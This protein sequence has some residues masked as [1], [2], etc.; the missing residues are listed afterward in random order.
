MSMENQKKV[1]RSWYVSH[2]PSP[3]LEKIREECGGISSSMLVEIALYHFVRCSQT[4]RAAIIAKY[5]DPN[6]PPKDES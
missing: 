1:K 6:W 4:E 5:F 2:D 3:D